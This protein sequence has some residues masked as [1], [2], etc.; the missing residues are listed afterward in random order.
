MGDRAVKTPQQKYYVVVMIVV[1]AAI[2][3]AAGVNKGSASSTKR[4]PM[5]SPVLSQTE[6]SSS[7]VTSDGVQMADEV[8]KNVQVLKGLSVD[9]F[10]GTMGIMSASLSMCC[11]ECHTGAGTDTVKW[12]VDTP[13]KR[14]ARRM[15]LMVEAI[16]KNNFGG[17]QL[18]T[19]WTCHRGR[20]FP[21]ITPDIEQ[22]VYGTP[23]FETDDV[24]RESF[25]GEPSANQIID[26]YVQAVGGAE[27]LAGMTSFSATGTSSG[28]G[29]LGGGGQV[30]VFAKA[31][32]QRATI[33]RFP[34]DPNRADEV[35]TFDGTAG[36]IAIPHAVVREYSLAG[37][38]LDGARLD[39]QLSFPG[40]IRQAVTNMHVGPPQTING[41]AVHVVQGTASRRLVAKLYFEDESGLLVRVVRFGASPI[42]RV[43]T[44]IDYGDYRSVNGIRIPFRWT[45]AW[46]DGRTVFQL[47]QVQL[48]TSID[49]SVFGRPTSAR[50]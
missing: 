9:D 21:T 7:A 18:V 26:K 8:F 2:V 25:P 41:K 6:S 12:E 22:D 13:R 40:Q 33:V 23:R 36:W 37:S 47:K 10:I 19:C 39:A 24:F 50:R 3:V 38:E 46:L 28:F 49:P 5:V 43:P 17:R 48:N 20:D 4:R 1:A 30:Q 11:N 29:G 15:V 32:A 14:T 27:R 31:P 34:S 45:F 35:R 42:G 44:Q 16:N